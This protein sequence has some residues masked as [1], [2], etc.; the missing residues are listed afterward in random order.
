VHA[1]VPAGGGISYWMRE[2]LAA[3]PGQP[4]P[5]L[6][7]DARADVVI[8]GGG[9]TGLW[10]AW[11]LS[12]RAPGIEVVVLERDVCGSGASG[13]NGGFV[14]PWWDEVDELAARYGDDA[15]LAACRASAESVAAVG[16]WC[17]EQGVDAWHRPADYLE[18]ASSR[19]QEG[20]WRSAVDAC[21]RLGMPDRYRELTAEEVQGVCR[22]PAF[23][24]GAAMRG[25]TVQPARLARGLRR[26]LLDRG[27]R[28]HERSP[29][30]GPPAGNP[31]VVET[32]VGLIRAGRAVVATNAWAA[33]W[34][35][36]RRQVVVRGSYI[37]LTAPAP[38]RLEDLGW[39]GGEPICDV[40]SALHYFRTTPDGRIAFGGVGRAL[41]AR[42]GPGYDHDEVSLGWV[43]E[44][45]RRIFPAFRDVPIE[46]GWGG[47]VDVSATHHPWFGSL[48]SATVHFGLGF[49]GHGVGQSYL[50]GR[51]LSALALD[52][53]DPW[54]A[55]PMVGREPK[56]FPPPFVSIPGTHVVQR[57]ILR[58]DRLE[59]VGRR[60]GLLTR[61]LAGLPRRLGFALGPSRR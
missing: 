39:I 42:V 17:L 10:T 47:A 34:P 53:D 5:P 23:G 15:A 18:V 22:S 30:V 13:R 61:W 25:A 1:A 35:P 20:V 49:T 14:G 21:R 57:A 45:F 11:F 32:S 8:L 55:L 4:C 36:F 51:I 16:D 3:D 7:G 12:E 48:P 26:V 9:Y 43:L 38:E 29:A 60:P 6:R 59:D 58:K 44:G 28:I 27:V 19:A 33:M 37:L 52:A 46:E 2:A 24:G 50:A 31:V 54:R 41:G 40:R 56:R